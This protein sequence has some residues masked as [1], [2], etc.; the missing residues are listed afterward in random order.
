M[1]AYEKSIYLPKQCTFSLFTESKRQPDRD[2]QRQQQ[3]QQKR[4]PQEQ[5]G[6]EGISR[7][8]D[9]R[10]GEIGAASASAISEDTM[11]IV[12]SGIV[13]GV[14]LVTTAVSISLG[15]GYV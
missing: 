7:P 4:R 13:S 6:Q 1:R 9:S 10:G 11:V 15:L 5:D 3:Q 2:V 14:V 12:V 8:A